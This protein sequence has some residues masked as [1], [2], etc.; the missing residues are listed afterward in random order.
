MDILAGMLAYIAGIGAILAGLAVS[1]SVFVATPNKPVEP[2]SATAMIVK[3]SAPNKAVAAEPIAEPASGHAEKNAAAV[4]A[5]A[6]AARPTR[7]GNETR[8][9]PGTSGASSA[10][11]TSAAQ[12]RQML[13]EERARR[14][15]SQHDPSFEHRFLGYA[16]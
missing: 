13:Q 11:A 3:P 4:N 14:W 10:A 5:P 1:F 6:D 15:V 16:D 2:Q 12:L 7:L 9:R 8:R